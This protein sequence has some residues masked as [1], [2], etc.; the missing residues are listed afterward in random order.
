MTFEELWEEIWQCC[1][2]PSMAQEQLP[3]SLSEATIKR[4]MRSR[5]K[6]AEI[7]VYIENAVSQIDHGSIETIDELIYSAVEDANV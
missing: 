4:L 3:K 5:M 2:L 7:A 6:P 1:H